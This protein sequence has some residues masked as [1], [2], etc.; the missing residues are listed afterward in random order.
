[1]IKMENKKTEGEIAIEKLKE[2]ED[3]LIERRKQTLNIIR[4]VVITIVSILA[5]I[6]IFAIAI[7]MELLSKA[8]C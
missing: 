2:I 3:S 6:G 5:L 8:G 1:M 4:G 7:V